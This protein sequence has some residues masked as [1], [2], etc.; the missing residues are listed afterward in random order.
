MIAAAAAQANT[1]AVV[2]QGL[3]IIA[4]LHSARSFPQP[5]ARL[6]AKMDE[7]DSCPLKRVLDRL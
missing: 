7:L 4:L 1:I 5:H 6:S 2:R 3:A